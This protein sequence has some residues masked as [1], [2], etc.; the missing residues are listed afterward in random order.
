VNALTYDFGL[1][2]VGIITGLVLL[3]G[4]AVVWFAPEWT[5]AGLRGFPRNLVV[6]RVLLVLATAWAVYLLATIDLG[7]FAGLRRMLVLGTIGAGV[8]TWIFV[9]EFLAVR[10]LAI[11]LLLAAEILLCAAYL[12]PPVSRLWLVFL[13]YGWI[14]AGL[15]FVGL[16]WLLRD[17]LNWVADRPWRLRL[18]A[19]AGMAY[20]AVVLL[21]ALLWYR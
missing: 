21:S 6:G 15:F 3:L 10:A 17:L 16:P 18:S 1:F 20:G 5:R 7:E 4:H 19:G 11:L 14:I 13:A 12:Q 2:P 9:E 8:L